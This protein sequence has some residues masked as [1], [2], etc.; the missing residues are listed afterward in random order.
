[1]R[2]F[3]A[4][5][6]LTALFAVSAHAEWVTEPVKWVIT[7]QGGPDGA[8]AIWH[9]D[10]LFNVIAAGQTDTTQIF[11][12][13][14]LE[15]M[16]KPS[17]A[18]GDTMVIGWLIFAQDSIGAT[19]ANITSITVE[20]D[21]SPLSVNGVVAGASGPWK[22]LDSL[23]VAQTP[24]DPDEQG[25]VVIPIRTRT[26]TLGNYDPGGVAESPKPK[27]LAFAFERFRA[28]ITAVT[29]VMTAAKAF[30]R[31]RKNVSGMGSR[32]Q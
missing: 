6:L 26:G 13:D 31:Y 15:D 28:R 7:N 2:K 4:A 12:L 3:I 30:V 9:R 14:N 21:G 23:V 11:V 25:A 20:I 27:L 22:Q 19:A 1:M 32:S 5:A 8:T 24:Y 10:T 16:T 29:G 18:V 17:A